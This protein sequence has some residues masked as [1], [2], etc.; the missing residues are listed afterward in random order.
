MI[1][2]QFPNVRTKTLSEYI[3][4]RSARRIDYTVL[5]DRFPDN[6][7]KKGPGGGFTDSRS[8]L[9]IAVNLGAGQ[10]LFRWNFG[11]FRLFSAIKLNSGVFA[12]IAPSTSG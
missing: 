3:P 1:C 10:V 11:L 12:L 2:L 5:G 7:V 4:A 6:D 8:G 9:L